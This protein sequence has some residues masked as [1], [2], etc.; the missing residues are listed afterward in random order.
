MEKELKTLT[1]WLKDS[2]LKVN[3]KNEVVLFYENYCKLITIRRNNNFITSASTM[4]VL[5]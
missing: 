5:G 3:E 4:N 1:K 2:G